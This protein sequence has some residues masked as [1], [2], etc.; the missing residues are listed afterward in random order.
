L[1]VMTAML[2]LGQIN[3][4]AQE[5]AQLKAQNERL[6]AALVQQ[7]TALA[8]RLEQLEQASHGATVAAR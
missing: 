1:R 6:Q 5:L 4:Q 3:V 7:T 8:A 2:G